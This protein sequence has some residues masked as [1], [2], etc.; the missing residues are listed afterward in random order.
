ME[1]E[2]NAIVLRAIAG[3]HTITDGSSEYTLRSDERLNR[4]DLLR[5]T[6]EISDNVIIPSKIEKLE[7]S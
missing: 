5:I 6:G 7:K 3:R 2:L 4:L 1:I